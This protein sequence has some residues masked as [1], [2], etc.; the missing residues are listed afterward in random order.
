M[1]QLFSLLGTLDSLGLAPAGD[2]PL[3]NGIRLAADSLARGD[4]SCDRLGS[5]D[6]TITHLSIRNNDEN[7][8]TAA[9]AAELRSGLN[10]TR[11]T[12]GC[13]S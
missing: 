13:T 10:A 9:Q 2:A 12:L 8:V 5:L 1:Q 3:R 4:M 6:E 7:A 11:S